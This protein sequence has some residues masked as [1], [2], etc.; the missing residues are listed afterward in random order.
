MAHRTPGEYT[1]EGIVL[2]GLVGRDILDKLQDFSF[3][4]SDIIIAAYPKSGMIVYMVSLSKL[5]V[6]YFLNFHQNGSVSSSL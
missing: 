2:L 4:D 3:A 5:W 1:H 6:R